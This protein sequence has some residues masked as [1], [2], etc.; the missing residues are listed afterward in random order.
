MIYKLFSFKQ[1]LFSEKLRFFIE[2]WELTPGNSENNDPRITLDSVKL[3]EKH[4][5]VTVV[6]E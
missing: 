3:N 6:H 1:K 2:I 5:E 4:V